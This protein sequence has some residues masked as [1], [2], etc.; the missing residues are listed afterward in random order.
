M[1][2]EQN[3]NLTSPAGR[4]TVTYLISNSYDSFSKTEKIIAD[5]LLS[6]KRLFVSSSITMLA[7]KLK[8]SPASI[9]RFCQKLNYRGFNDLKYN[10]ANNMTLPFEQD[11]KLST[12]DSVGNIIYKLTSINQA[13]IL[14]SLSRLNIDTVSAAVNMICAA[15][16]IHIYAEGGPGIAAS[17]AYQQ[18]LKLGFACNYFTDTQLAMVAAAQLKSRDVCI[19][20]C[21]TG[22]SKNMMQAVDIAKKGRAT[23]IGISANSKSDLAATSNILLRYSAP[24]ENDLRYLHVARICEIAVIGV[25]FASIANSEPERFAQNAVNSAKMLMTNSR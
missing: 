10:I 25:L 7:R 8:V 21:R 9:T 12:D 18:L 5:H 20:I 19:C 15:K 1:Q 23:I 6:D 13:A 11:G 4:S 17:Y 16:T 14:D 2:Q 3:P 24:I 22:Y